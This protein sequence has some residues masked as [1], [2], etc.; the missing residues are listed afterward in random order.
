M[1]PGA[2]PG[3]SGPA[4]QTATQSVVPSGWSV[5]AGKS[6]GEKEGDERMR[7]A[8]QP[9]AGDSWQLHFLPCQLI[10]GRLRSVMLMP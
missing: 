5:A 3:G 7:S 2:A 4:G 8:V 10:L 1:G 9:L 6:E